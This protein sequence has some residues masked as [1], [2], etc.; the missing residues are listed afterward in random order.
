MI[1]FS[2]ITNRLSI[3]VAGLIII[4]L[5]SSNLPALALNLFVSI[6]ILEV[7]NKYTLL[8]QCDLMLCV[9]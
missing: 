8:R 9:K 5:F 4:Y 7:N 6:M 3:T 2:V 1:K